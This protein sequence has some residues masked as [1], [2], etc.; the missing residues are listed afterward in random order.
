LSEVKSSDL[1]QWL[2]ALVAK[3]VKPI[4]ERASYLVSRSI[5]ALGNIRK[6]ATALSEDVSS[7]SSTESSKIEIA[8]NFGARITGLVDEVKEPETISHETLLS[9]LSGLRKF[10]AGLIYAGA[11]W[12][13]KLDP[14]YKETIR[15]MEL[16]L[17][18]IRTNGKLLEE[19]LD[20]K[21]SA[22]RKYETL[23]KEAETLRI[24]SD[25]LV[26]LE[27]E[28]RK[29]K[30]QRET[31]QAS[32]KAL[33]EDKR[34]L[35]AS[36]RL[37]E[38]SRLE[39]MKDVAR[40]EIVNLF[41]PLEKPVEKLLKL[42]ERER[43]RLDPSAATILSEYVTDPVEKLC[44]SDIDYSRLAT[45]LSGFQSMLERK[46][47]D[48]KD[49]RIRAALKRISL[50][51]DRSNPERLRKEY[52]EASEAYEQTSRSPEVQSLLLKREEMDSKRMETEEDMGRLDR[53]LS[54]MH[55]RKEELSKRFTQLREGVEKAIEEVTGQTI[56]IPDPLPS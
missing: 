30:S 2:E 42:P 47:L 19:H 56:R 1:P 36:E 52:L 10:H 14:K 5:E 20:R 11:I 18:D 16:S 17:S 49:S 33:A 13:R 43:Q 12:I 44:K 26:R 7:A 34:Q 41:R 53:T 40:G 25:E 31:L 51:K 4:K 3:D 8:K 29:I 24:A 48:L 6:T 15:K 37:A 27:D 39:S 46:E 55:V 22:V 32:L 9:F 50:I 21:Y 28:I 38:L 35:E 45:S 54:S 23:L